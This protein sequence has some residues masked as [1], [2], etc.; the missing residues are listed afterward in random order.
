MRP[1]DRFAGA[2]SRTTMTSVLKPSSAKLARLLAATLLV[3]ASVP[4]SSSAAGPAVNVVQAQ[5]RHQTPALPGIPEREVSLLTYG[6]NGN[7][8]AM[9]TS[10]FAAAI[11][12][13]AD[14][15]GGTV[16]IPSGVWLTGPVILRSKVRLHLDAGALILF[17]PDRARYPLISTTWEGNTAVR[18]LAP[19]SG[20]NLEDVAITGDGV[21]DGSGQAWRPVKKDKLTESQWRRLLASGGVTDDAKRIWYPTPGALLGATDSKLR[22]SQAKADQ[23]KIRDFLRPVLLNL[24]NCKRVLLEGVTFQNS[25]AWT[26]HPLLCEDLTVRRISVRNPWYAQNG[27]GLDL[28]SCRRVLVEHSTFDVGDDAICL[29][30]GRDAEGR[31]RGRP[32]EDVLIRDCTVQ[33][34]HGGFV[35]GSE[36]SGGVRNI[37]VERCTF[38]GTDVGLRFKSTRGRGGVVENVR[39]SDVRMLN[40]AGEAILFDLFY[41]GRKPAGQVVIPPVTEET[42]AFRDIHMTRIVSTGARRSA[43]LQGLPEM[44]LSGITLE[45]SSLSGDLGIHIVDTKGVVL[46]RVEVHSTEGAAVQVSNASEVLLDSVNATA[47]ASEPKIAVLGDRTGG[48]LLRKVSGLERPG[49]LSVDKAVPADVVKQD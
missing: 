25:P 12:A 27:D 5:P 33:H 29:K 4:V 17:T 31:R 8:I 45:D 26:V 22:A 2:V 28:E 43:F 30:S 23:E 36:M 39:I 14:A 38:L 44:P 11:A 37:T 19:L 24:V 15:G 16:R 32:T 20:T 21:I 35:I 42:P 9:N 34:G 3:A 13:V 40:I 1:R 6:G 7:G 47:P 10:A 18:C 41:M 46:R 49:A 48:V